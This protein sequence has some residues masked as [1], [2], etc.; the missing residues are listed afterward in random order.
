MKWPLRGWPLSLPPIDGPGDFGYGRA[1]YRHPGIDLYCP[2]GWLVQAMEP[3]VVVLVDHF[4]GPGSIPTSPWWNDTWSVMIEGASGVLG[5]CELESFVRVGDEVK[6]GQPLGR[7]L[8]V[9]KR[10]KGNGTSM[11]H[12]EQYIAGTN[13]HAVWE[14]NP[15][16][17]NG[18]LIQSDVPT[19]L[20]NP[21]P[22]LQRVMSDFGEIK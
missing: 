9:L 10:D 19:G 8:P 11:L 7:V 14:N 13:E 20:L 16:R 15:I 12:F 17:E 3:G 18:V 1:F 2:A 4:T 5:Y 6:E 21:R 22:L